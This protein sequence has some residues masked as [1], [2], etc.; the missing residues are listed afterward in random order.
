MYTVTSDLTIKVKGIIKVV[1]VGSVINLP[2]KS[3]Q[4]F[5]QQGKLVPVQEK[6]QVIN[7]ESE[8]ENYF[9]VAVERIN[10]HYQAGTIDYIRQKY[11]GRFQESLQIE[12]RLNSFWYKDFQEFKKGVDDWRE[13]E[14]ELIKLF[15]QDVN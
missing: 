6:P 9:Q 5:I 10:N 15:K 7:N 4:L 12:N 3:A 14:L 1:T 11:P 13:V 2:E 8:Y